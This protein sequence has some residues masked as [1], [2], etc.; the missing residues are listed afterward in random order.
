M[1]LVVILLWVL[2]ALSV[3]ALSFASLLVGDEC[4]A[5]F[6]ASPPHHL[7]VCFVSAASCVNSSKV[8]TI[9]CVRE[10]GIEGAME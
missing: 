2:E 4:A 10:C 3:N 1:C 8:R 7:R 6:A 5:R 9:P